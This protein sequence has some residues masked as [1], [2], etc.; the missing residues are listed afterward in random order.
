ME[1][2][3]TRTEE[4]E[5]YF[6]YSAEYGIFCVTLATPKLLALRKAQINLAF[7]SFFRNFAIKDGEI[8]RS[9][10]GNFSV[11]TKK[12][13]GFFVL[14]STFR[15]FGNAELTLHSE[16]LKYIWLFLRFFVTLQQK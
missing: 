3:V 14:C 10:Q 16:K 9:A 2:F 4:I 6:P 15:N 11:S 1:P 7:H 13:T 5:K 8:F 12:E